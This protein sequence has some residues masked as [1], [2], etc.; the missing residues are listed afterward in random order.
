VIDV[1]PGVGIV[2]TPE[3]QQIKESVDAALHRFGLHA[4]ITAGFDGQHRLDSKHY[5]NAAL[6]FRIVWTSAQRDA[7][8]EAIKQELPIGYRMRLE[9]DHL[10]VERAIVPDNLGV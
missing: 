8:L 7:L 2:M 6:D 1:K 10:H 3:N 4:V 5:H 9:A